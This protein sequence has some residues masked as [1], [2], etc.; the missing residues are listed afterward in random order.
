MHVLE[1]NGAAD[2]ISVSWKE[3]IGN[4]LTVGA[5]PSQWKTWIALFPFAAAHILRTRRY[6]LQQAS[7]S[8]LLERPHEGRLLYEKRGLADFCEINRSLKAFR[9]TIRPRSSQQPHTQN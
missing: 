4:L 3:A 9:E 1:P 8:R 2:W 6:S 5:Y 7:T